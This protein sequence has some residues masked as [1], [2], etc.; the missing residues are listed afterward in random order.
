MLL[1]ILYVFSRFPKEGIR[2]KD[3]NLLLEIFII[4]SN[5]TEI[6]LGYKNASNVSYILKI[7]ADNFI[8][9]ETNYNSKKVILKKNQNNYILFDYKTHDFTVKVS[10]WNHQQYEKSFYNVDSKIIE[11][12]VSGY[13][14]FDHN[15]IIK[16]L[17]SNSK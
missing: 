7:M 4:D 3:N 13:F 14:D 12:V 10:F 11:K 6:S 2:D 9:N 15:F 16:Y 17:E 1:G 5:F 8:Y